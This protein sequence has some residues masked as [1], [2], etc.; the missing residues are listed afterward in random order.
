MIETERLILRKP[1]LE[2]FEPHTGMW[3]EPEVFRHISG[4]KRSREEIWQR[5][6]QTYGNWH[7]FGFGYFSVIEK[8]S[9][10]YVGIVGFQ[11]G[12]RE[13][14]PSLEGSLEA[15]WVFVPGVH[16]KGYASEACYALFA[17]ARGAHPG[18]KVTAII[19]PDNAA[20]IKI[21]HKLG[22]EAGPDAT[23]HGS[24]VTVFEGWLGAAA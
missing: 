1:I 22:L 7:F 2:D 19:D 14:E 9:G 11:E 15:G 17:W 12:L 16:G 8:A 21:A 23:Y 20:S 6:L 3:Q 4:K 24:V 5:F 10:R 18:R 13:M